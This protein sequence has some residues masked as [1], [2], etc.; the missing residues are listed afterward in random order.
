MPPTAEIKQMACRLGADL[1]GIA[2]IDRFHDAPEGF[3]PWDVLPSCQSVIVLAKKF[4]AATLQC[5]S[6]VP[7]TIARNMLSDV[8]DKM[9][10]QLCG[11]LEECGIA[12]VP[13]GSITHSQYDPKTGRWRNIVSVKHCAVA[14][15]LGRLGRNTLVTTPEYGNMLWFHAV[16]TDA[17]LDADPMLTG[18]PCPEGCSLCEDICPAGALGSMEMNQNACFAHAFRTEP[19]QEFTFKCHACRTQ[20]PNCLGSKNTPA[21]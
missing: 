11:D 4:P 12:A 18:D 14:A 21:R 17:L 20:C 19:G 10:V 6:A 9:A 5:K 1:C 15:G 16:L 3:H 2:S 13:T 7:Y 8:L